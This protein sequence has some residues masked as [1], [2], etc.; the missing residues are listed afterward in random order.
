MSTLL[1]DQL[2]QSDNLDGRKAFVHETSAKS[3]A[4]Q[5]AWR[6]AAELATKVGSR[7]DFTHRTDRMRTLNRE[8]VR[9]EVWLE[10]I[11]RPG[12]HAQAT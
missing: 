8:Q 5:A 11:G 7:V 9:R 4:L 2:L 10:Q 1:A 6:F 3:K 12:R